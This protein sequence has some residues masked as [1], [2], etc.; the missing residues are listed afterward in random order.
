MRGI[1]KLF[2]FLIAAAVLL[3]FP[4]PASQV[5][6]DTGTIA[7]NLI[8]SVVI[9]DE[10]GQEIQNVRL[11]QGARV[12]VDFTWKFPADH[13]YKAGST[14]V[15]D[16]PDKF[17]VGSELTGK[18]EGDVGEI[19]TYK[20]TP[21]GQVTFTFNESIEGEE[22][23]GNF[24][25]WRQFNK[26]KLSGSTQQEIEFQ[27]DGNVYANI[28]VHFKSAATSNIDKSG[29]PD[30]EM[31]PSSI[32]WV[33]RFNM[34]EDSIK[35]AVFKDTLPDGLAID[36]ASV[37]A[38]K[39]DV[40][41]DGSTVVGEPATPAFDSTKPTEFSLAFG[42]IDG[43]Y[44]VEYTTK[45]TGTGNKTYTN[46]AEVTEDG[47]TKLTD[48]DSV[49]AKYIPPLD[50]KTTSYDSVTQTVGWSIQMNLNER[51][52]DQVDAKLT[53]TFGPLEKLVSLEVF[54]L[55]VDASGKATRS[56][57]ALAEGTAYT[58]DKD[59]TNGAFTLQFLHDIDSAYEIAYQT[60]SKERVFADRPIKNTVVFGTETKEATRNIQQ[61]IFRKNNG[62]VNY[63]SKTIAWSLNLNNDNKPMDQVVITDTYAA[64][65]G[66][67]F[68]PGTLKIGTLKVNEDY[69]VEPKTSYM[70][71]F[72]ITFLKP[73]SSAL[74]IDY[75]TRFDSTVIADRKLSQ[76]SNTAKLDWEESDGTA[77][78]ITKTGTA[79]IDQ[80]SQGNGNKTGSYDA[81]TKEITW[82]IDLNYN[83]HDI[84]NAIV[85]DFYTG[86]ETFVENSLEVRHLNL[87]SGENGVSP[88][89]LVPGP[90]NADYSVKD[91]G[92][93]GFK[94]T[95]G[96]I[97]SA[98][99]ITY[100]TSLKGQ[101]VGT[102]YKNHATLID[103]D[104]P[105][106]LL[107]N[108]SATVSPNYGNEFIYKEGSQGTGA[109]QDYAFWTVDI[110]R[111]QSLVEAGAKLTDTLSSNQVLVPDSFKLFATT[112]D[113]DG[114]PTK[115]GEVDPSKYS[116]DVQGNAFALT[117]K[118]AIE[119]S[120]VLEYKSFLN[121][122][123]GET[124][125]NDAKFAGQSSGSAQQSEK[126]DII[127]SLSGAGG[128][129]S[130]PGKGDLTLVKVDASDASKGLQG[131]VFGLYDKTGTTLIG[132]QTTDGEGKAVFP[133]IRY[134]EYLLRELAAPSGYLIDEEYQH[135]K[136]ISFT[137]S[138][139]T[140]T[141]ANVKGVWA[142][143][144]TKVD[145]DTGAMLPGA[146]FKLQAKNGDKYEDVALA[147]P[148]V[149]DSQGKIYLPE[150]DPGDYQLIET[151]APR[152]YRLNSAPIPF[153]I[154]SRQ[155]AAKTATME[156]ER[157]VGSVELKKFD[158]L[159]GAGLADAVFELQD[160]NGVVLQKDLKTN[161]EGKLVVD[162][163]KSGKYQ[164]VEVAPPITYVADATPIQFEIVQDGETVPL[165]F[166]N[167][168]FDGVWAF[169]LTK[170]DKDTGAKLPGAVFKLQAKNGD[171][172][173]DVALAS[174]LV[175]DSQGKI[176]LPELPPGDYQL[177]ETEAPR[178]YRLNPAP[179][180][181]SID[182]YQSAAKTA[183]MENERNVGSVELKKVDS[184]DGAGL[185]GA[186][187]E[188]Q[189]ENGV[190]LQKDLRTDAEGKLVID[191][192]KSGKYQFVEVAPP[193]S[194]AADA[195]PIKFE[196]VQ[197]GENV[198]LTFGNRKNA[199]VLAFELTKVDKDTGAKLP[200]AVFKLQ[201]KNGDKYE[202][203]A[204]SS[205]LVTDSQGKI[206]LP[207]LTPGDY[208]L[209]ET[210]APR[211]YRLNPA[212]IP[213]TIDARQTI[214]KAATMENERNVGSV[215]LKKIDSYD[216]AAL[217][218]AAFELQDE[219]GAVLQ[220]DLKTNAEGKLIVSGL[221]SGKYQFVEVAPPAGYGANATPVKFEIVQDG[222][223]VQLTFENQILTGS[224]TLTK[225][226]TG[227]SGRKLSGAVFRLLDE[228]KNPV[229][230]REGRAIEN[231]KTDAN[232]QLH[233]SGLRPG[234]YIFEETKAPSGYAIKTK[235]TEFTVA[236]GQD[237]AVTVVNS[238]RSS[239]SGPDPVPEEPQPTNPVDPTTP[240]NPT[241]PTTPVD[242]GTPTT[243]VDPGTP[244]TPV[245]PTEPGDG[246]QPTK[247]GSP[248]PHKPG[249][250]VTTPKN[251]SVKGKV[252][253][254]KGAQASV[255]SKPAR[256]TVTVDA[257]G[258][259][260]YTPKQGYTGK[261]SFTVA[262]SDG[263]EI[264]VEVNVVP[265]Q[266]AA[267]N[268]GDEGSAA[269]R[270]PKTGE[271]MPLVSLFGYILT[272]SA[273]ILLTARWFARRRTTR[274]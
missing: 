223:N 270:L 233:V 10:D 47:A 22:L 259:W 175:T 62:T 232:G 45:I 215:E 141:I 111:S 193:L 21:E 115:A 85:Q 37:K 96:K 100:K 197:D 146:V 23:T 256:G 49:S 214:A 120:Y 163:L 138:T 268:G 198:K 103:E 139:G 242:P 130:T 27:Y 71:G 65:Q 255:G 143:E 164:F 155:T 46:K 59:D 230:D 72:V 159:N 210:E 150:L 213:F 95:L 234:K 53:D 52:I 105:A 68:L 55:T 80:F 131:A 245:D 157:N 231:L 67:E 110:N 51:Q 250:E 81:R 171:K 64:N 264:T 168:K 39:L 6:A 119:E 136:L 249:K 216:G 73:I 121:A 154:D 58:V 26:S 86:A 174:A 211:G 90:Y 261:D 78:T 167:R 203:V 247:P 38:F 201:A 112:V 217:E 227:T 237:T 185:E 33:V 187:F 204:A 7:E 94:L 225:V 221:K 74:K 87:T 186:V 263:E 183:T 145:K 160:E 129:A 181:F 89:A 244:T 44:Q 169:E 262:T 18:L 16:L 108:K 170:V 30:K 161:A 202:D 132:T 246:G 241:T 219:N 191:G 125:T 172:Y 70:E 25:V 69:K 189:D 128:G 48:S 12:Q 91:N 124:V 43:A 192:L 254:P 101:R 178:G 118:E 252:D 102:E 36:P 135:G 54:P 40:Q 63:A 239:G 107:F 75:E 176:Y 34:K 60:T 177:I 35:N 238:P 127:V 2:V 8:Q 273:L 61:V 5:H 133:G 24:Y 14:F 126:S 182:G 228:N 77:K 162:G 29:T 194:Y 1:R 147:S 158:P 106:T 82:T 97:N 20:V 166:A 84:D 42:D 274:G 190:V 28:P 99:R 83:L 50:K 265:A 153:T 248:K 165:T 156:N 104:D 257:K 88:G 200:G 240:T 17:K 224:V 206:Y 208:Q 222:E 272:A 212:P 41:L 116:L 188:L 4:L 93:S 152:G 3:N 19:G 9:T 207:E 31:N 258:N 142:F 199:G 122:D 92:N 109:E 134:K 267:D 15:F 76:Y 117:F 151:E 11:D 66:L 184:Y 148:L 113:K 56:G 251:T 13:E 149:T 205:A 209:I 218:G 98:Y 235:Y 243:P 269:G 140:L 179:I 114:N 32:D 253:V 196:I 271:S 226:R 236:Y 195:T 220:K 79:K 57:A 260:K 173:D 266:A 229:K 123:D 144:L 180:P 137:N